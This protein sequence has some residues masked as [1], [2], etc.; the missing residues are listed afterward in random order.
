MLKRQKVILAILE[1]VDRPLDRIVLVKYAF[2]LSQETELRNEPAF[3]NF[4]PYKYGPFSFTLYHELENL[5]RGRY[6]VLSETEV[7]V[8]ANARKSAA[9]K[10]AELPSQARYAV[11]SVL[12]RYDRMCR[13]SLLKDVYRRYPWYATSSELTDLVRNRAPKL[14]RARIA[15]YTVGYEG[16]SIDGFLN[17]LLRT[18]IRTIID[19]RANPVSRKYGFAGKS[20]ARIAGRVGLAYHHFPELG[21][22]TSRRAGLTD[23]ESYRVLLNRYESQLVS[24]QKQDVLRV[25]RLVRE[26][27]SALLCME[28]DVQRCHRGRLALAAGRAS[29]LPVVH[30]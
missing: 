17:G 14:R 13:N 27:P 12:G 30:L 7:A 23:M 20:L 6:V 15:V 28:A 4:V 24:R 5:R 26:T 1:C 29:G 25:V 3:Y 11:Q 18:G 16:K 19:V 9:R 21:I 8:E 2:L 10:A 22:P